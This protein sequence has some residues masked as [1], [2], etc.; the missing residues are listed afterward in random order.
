MKILLLNSNPVVNKLVTLS[1]QKTSDELDVAGSVEEVGFKNYDLL[2]VDDAM[3]DE[4]AMQELGSKIEFSKS[5]YI[6][7]KE[8][9]PLDGFNATLKKP[10]LPTDLVELLISLGK[11]ADVVELDKKNKGNDFIELNDETI[12]E[13]IDEGLGSLDDFDTVDEI[14]GLEELEGLG[15]I[16]ELD[17]MENLDA[18]DADEILNLDEFDDLEG[19][20]ELELNDELDLEDFSEDEEFDEIKKLDSSQEKIEGVLDRD[21]LQEVQNL[22]EETE[23]EEDDFEGLKEDTEYDFELEEDLEPDEEV[24]ETEEVKDLDIKESESEEES[25]DELEDL[26]AQIENA[27]LDLSDE[28]L[29]SE[30]DEDML[31]NMDSLTSRDLKLAIGEEVDEEQYDEQIEDEDFAEDIA[32]EEEEFEKEISNSADVSS[33]NNND[34]VEALKKILKALS[35]EDV[36]ASL[37][38]MKISINITL[39]D[40]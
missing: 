27:V 2:I 23:K 26:E 12:D 29:A 38:G 11:S 31:L 39:G 6:C 24:N 13:I 32:R 17:E 20:E 16:D 40:K 15:E 9:K 25:F 36:A 21:E 7:S 30:I 34:G 3:Y 8:G 35:N 19:D 22:L 4:D 1:A 37:K 10:F 33:Q 5:L 28:D 14:D 18:K